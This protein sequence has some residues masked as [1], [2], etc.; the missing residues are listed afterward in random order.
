VTARR[1]SRM[2]VRRWGVV[3][4]A[5]AVLCG[6]SADVPE[7]GATVTGTVLLGPTCP[8]ETLD[9]PCPPAP[10]AGAA[11]EVSKTGEVFATTT[12]DADGRFA[13]TAPTGDVEVR[14]RS[15]E[16][17]PSEDVR[18]L[19]LSAGDDVELELTLDTGIR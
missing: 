18:V 19:T 7:R 14:A 2:T 8:V 1:P 6:C 16:G 5:L 13:L 17:V 4:V 15:A 12:T 9:S 10:A 11:V 3:L